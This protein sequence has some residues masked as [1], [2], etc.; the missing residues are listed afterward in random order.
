MKT[1]HV[2]VVGWSVQNNVAEGIQD[3]IWADEVTQELEKETGS[4]L[5]QTAEGL[6]V[7]VSHSRMC[8]LTR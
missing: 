2:D 5:G 7:M 4:D 8:D 1:Q 6:L 3:H